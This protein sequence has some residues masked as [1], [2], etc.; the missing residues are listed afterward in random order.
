MTPIKQPGKHPDSKSVSKTSS[1]AATVGETT[2]NGLPVLTEVVDKA[3]TYLP[4][5]LSEEEIQRLLPQ[6]EAH[7]EALF[8]KKLA[9]HLEQLQR[10]AI[11]QA[12]RELKTE[13]P[14]LLHEALYTYLDSSE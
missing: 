7:I 1:P 13:L 12:I 9:L 3:D 6:L 14:E 2:L 11:E 10:Q 8:T 4:R 5:L